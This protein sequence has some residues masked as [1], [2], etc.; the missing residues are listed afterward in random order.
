MRSDLTRSVF[1]TILR[2]Y[3]I[4]NLHGVTICRELIHSDQINKSEHG[5]TDR[6]IKRVWL[7]TVGFAPRSSLARDV[8]SAARNVLSSLA[9][10]KI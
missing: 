3:R 8:A 2:I 5:E 1:S 9:A 6:Q 10:A 4:G 7:D